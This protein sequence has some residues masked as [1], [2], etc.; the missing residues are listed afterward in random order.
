MNWKE[1]FRPTVSKIAISVVLFVIFVPFIEPHGFQ[2]IKAPCP[3]PGT[4]SLLTQFLIFLTLGNPIVGIHYVN[5][6]VGLIMSY[7]LS[8]LIISGINKTKKK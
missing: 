5:L 7:L 4:Q 8:C 1:F 3:Q 2:C 6:F